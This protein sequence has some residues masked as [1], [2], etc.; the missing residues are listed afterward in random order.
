M[1]TI[2][3][4]FAILALFIQFGLQAQNDNPSPLTDTIA[5][6]VM[7]E[8]NYLMD[9]TVVEAPAAYEE[10]IPKLYPIEKK[11]ITEI[12]SNPDKPAKYPGGIQ[13][14][15][16]KINDNLVVPYSYM[17][18]AQFVYLEV[19]VG[20]DSMLYNANPLNTPG[21]NYTEN[22]IAALEALDIKFIPATKNGKPVNSILVIPIRFETYIRN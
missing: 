14:L 11:K 10:Y 5:A 9:A 21:Y 20:K 22:A 12:I 16:S 13:T 7:E 3:Y 4:L 8:D 15:M 6:P 18:N 1:K 2:Q 19:V 17:N